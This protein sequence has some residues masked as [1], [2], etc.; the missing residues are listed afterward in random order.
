MERNYIKINEE[1]L[2]I[3]EEFFGNEK[4]F[5]EWLA[6]VFK[7]YRGKNLKIK[8]KIVLKYFNTYKKTMDFIMNSVKN[9]KKSLPQVVEN[10]E[11]MTQTP[12]TPLYS[13]LYSPLPIP[14][15]I[16]PP[17][18][19]KVISNNIKIINNNN[20]K[21]KN[22]FLSENLTKPKIL[23]SQIEQYFLDLPN[24]SYFKDFETKFKIDNQTL[25]NFIEPFKIKAE[26]RYQNFDR[27]ISHFK[28][29]VLVELE[30]KIKNKKDSS[31]ELQNVAVFHFERILNKHN[32]LENDANN[33]QITQ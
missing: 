17:P 3:A 4:H 21:E 18:N 14:L 10:K 16:P 30:K 6:N 33:L 29:F 15:V 12:P 22:N 2:L 20:S 27:F 24:S 7:Y 25:L 28:N 23:I 26:V 32:Q 13:P 31:E 5:D 9:G 1:D 8:T 11:V 19:N